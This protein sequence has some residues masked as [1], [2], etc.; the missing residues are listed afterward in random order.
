[1]NEYNSDDHL[2]K[3]K[4]KKQLKT[5]G[6]QNDN[7]TVKVLINFPPLNGCA[8]ASDVQMWLPLSFTMSIKQADINLQLTCTYWNTTDLFT[9]DYH[10]INTRTRS[11]PEQCLGNEACSPYH[12]L[13][14]ASGYKARCSIR[15][16][17]PSQVHPLLWTSP[18]C[19]TGFESWT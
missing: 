11:Y 4:N 2:N 8:V 12:T 18:T 1:M 19:S 13:S 3:T 10:S 14:N 17:T 5:W 6:V 15:I 7:F 16:Q 9:C